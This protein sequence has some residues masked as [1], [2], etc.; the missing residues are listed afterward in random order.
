MLYLFNGAY[1]WSLWRQSDSCI[2]KDEV[3]QRH[4]RFSSMTESWN[5]HL[6]LQKP[7]TRV[8][9]LSG[10]D[11]F[12]NRRLHTDYI[13]H[14]FFRSLVFSSYHPFIVCFHVFI[15]HIQTSVQ[16]FKFATVHLSG[17]ADSI[18]RFIGISCKRCSKRHLP[19]THSHPYKYSPRPMLL[20]LKDTTE[21]GDR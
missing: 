12:E 3:F 14:V 15:L 16:Q 20:N 7:G 18:R 13:L 8:E 10:S 11:G 17:L 4:F 6:S 1:H 5:G 2:H 9:D 21:A 19:A